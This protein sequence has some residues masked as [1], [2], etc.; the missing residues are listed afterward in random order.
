LWG[1]VAQLVDRHFAPH[2][3]EAVAAR[4]GELHYAG[5][6]ALNLEDIDDIAQTILRESAPR[7]GA[8]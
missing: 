1:G 8:L 5:L 3:R 4:F 6:R 7:E 2:A